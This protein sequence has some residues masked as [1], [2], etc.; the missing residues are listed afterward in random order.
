MR[1]VKQRLF[2]DV[3]FNTEFKGRDTW[4]DIVLVY[5]GDRM[6]GTETGNVSRDDL[7][8]KNLR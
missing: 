8:E 3:R 6:R 1:S 5:G 7:P 2:I 4:T